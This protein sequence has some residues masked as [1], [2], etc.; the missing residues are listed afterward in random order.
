MIMGAE[1]VASLRHE[2]STVDGPLI[3]SLGLRYPFAA[4][5]TE[6][7]GFCFLNQ[8]ALLRSSYVA[9]TSPVAMESLALGLPKLGVSGYIETAEN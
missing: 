8:R 4:P 2:P 9:D 3:A 7:L 5:F 6:V 1:S